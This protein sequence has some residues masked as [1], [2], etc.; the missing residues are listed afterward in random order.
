MAGGDTRA[1]VSKPSEMDENDGNKAIR[2][3]L[4]ML[5]S[6]V[7]T[8]TANFMVDASVCC[9]QMHPALNADRHALPP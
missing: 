4:S 1:V 6:E 2:T 3:V 8:E 7:A 9:L 5:S